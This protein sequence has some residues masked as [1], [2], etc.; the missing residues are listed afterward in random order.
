MAFIFIP[1]GASPTNLLFRPFS[2]PL[3]QKTLSTPLSTVPPKFVIKEKSMN[4]DV[5]LLFTLV[6]M[7]F[8]LVTMLL[9]LV[10]LLLTLVTMLLTL[11][12]MLLTLVT[13]LLTLVSSMVTLVNRRT[14]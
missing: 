4:A 10:T 12:T 1:S 11:V 13:M 14:T 8:T 6:T 9:T 3:P 5:N 7:L 2:L